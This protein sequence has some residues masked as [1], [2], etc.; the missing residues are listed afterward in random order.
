[1]PPDDLER[2]PRNLL[3]IKAD[4]YVSAFADGPPAGARTPGVHHGQIGSVKTPA[5]FLAQWRPDRNAPDQEIVGRWRAADLAV[6]GDAVLPNDSFKRSRVSLVTLEIRQQ[7]LIAAPANS[8]DMPATAPR[9]VLDLQRCRVDRD[10]IVAGSRNVA[11]RCGGRADWHVH[12]PP[13]FSFV[14]INIC[15]VNCGPVPVG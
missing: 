4:E 2:A 8:D 14:Y 12:E 1:M 9:M 10:A 7:K 11:A 6:I 5:T 3:G 15:M 13:Y